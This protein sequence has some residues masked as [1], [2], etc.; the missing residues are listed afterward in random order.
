M[1]YRIRGL[2]PAPFAPLFA[3]DDAQLA[4]HRATRVVADA[5]RGFPCRVSLDDA[6]AGETLLLLSYCSHAVDG[7]YRTSYAI[8]VR[9]SAQRRAD[10]VDRLPPVFAGRNLS[11]RGFDREAM[12]CDARLA[13][14][15]DVEDAIH[16]LFADRRIAYIHAHNAAYGC[17]AAQI[18]RHEGPD[19]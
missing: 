6:A 10:Y 9:Q 4:G 13:S 11:L 16:A 3:L 5:P 17:F 7:P 19:Q 18:D 8:Y 14:S 15:D 1:V 2:D 12:L